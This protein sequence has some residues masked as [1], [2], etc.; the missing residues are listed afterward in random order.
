MDFKFE[1][2]VLKLIPETD[3]DRAKMAA[4]FGEAQSR[5]ARY[6]GR[7]FSGPAFGYDITLQDD[8]SV[9]VGAK[10]AWWNYDD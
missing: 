7:E 5:E 9:D 4:T 10:D 8:G 1:E 3:E 6:K 2:G